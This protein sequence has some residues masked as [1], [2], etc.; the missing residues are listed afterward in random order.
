MKWKEYDI[1]LCCIMS[2]RIYSSSNGAEYWDRIPSA[3]SL[4]TKCTLVN[5]YIHAGIEQLLV[6]YWDRIPSAH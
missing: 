5:N 4:N 1:Q 3:H 2:F 6:E